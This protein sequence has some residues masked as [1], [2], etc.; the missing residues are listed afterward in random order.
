M[1]GL[2]A[3]FKLFDGYS[4]TI[5][6][7][8]PKTDAATNKILNASGATDKLN[9]KLAATGVSAGSAAK[10]LDKTVQKTDKMADDLSNASG[11]TDKL[12]KKLGATGAGASSAA[13]GL[14]KFIKAA[15]T[16]AM[17]KKGMDIVD[18]YANTSA[19]LALINDGLQTQ[20]ELQDKVFALAERSRGSYNDMASA[21]AKMG[22]LAKDA[23]TDNDELLAFTELVQKSFKIGGA[24][25]SEQQG[26][27][28]QLSQAMASG[29]LQG[30]ELVSI[31]ENAPMIY[32]AI[33]KYTGKSKG[34]LKKLSSDG[35]ITSQIIKDSMFMA[36]DDINS[37]F[38][39]M[40]KTFADGWTRMKDGAL[41]AFGPVMQN[42]IAILNRPETTAFI[43]GFTS[44]LNFIAFAINIIISTIGEV[45][46][47]ISYFWP[48]IEPIL[49]AIGAALLLW[50]VTQ[51]PMLITKLW[52][53]VAP[54]LA[55]AGAWALANMPILL[56]GAA[57][58]LLLYAILKFG[59]TVIE[60]VGVIGGIF[61]GLYAFML[62][63][64]AAMVNPFIS[65][66][67]FFAN[68]FNNPVYSIKKLFVDLAT[69]VLNLLQSIAEGIDNVLGS[70]M[71]DGLQ[72]LKDNMSEWLG[73][74]PEN[75]KEFTKMKMVDIAEYANNGYDVGKQAGSWA[76]NGVQDI[77]SKL[78][79]LFGMS[80]KGTDTPVK[81][82]GT[83][84][85]GSVQVNMAD[86]DLQYLRDIAERDYVANVANNTLAPQVTF[87]FGDIRETA[88]ADAIKKRLEEIMR[89]EIAV[90]SEGV[91]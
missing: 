16:L 45:I 33:A 86:E 67:E 12:N 66:A 8:I 25:T 7:I 37:K 41:K 17:L 51:I 84:S 52:L 40:P 64:I 28:R 34:E 1:V 13:A 91:Y 21:I 10:G 47:L 70:N 82:K 4:S 46:D 6:K 63:G 39:S 56:L 26:A 90:S 2:N 54:I 60:V 88:D 68:V 77:A 32:E 3:I 65:F 24:D 48:V 59:D 53:M 20:A 14:G 57:I 87:Q 61:G 62:N 15:I 49:V 69:N 19:R 74:K 31:M 73:D 55:Q 22:L 76:V 58:G 43:D 78:G 29:R 72:N 18:E 79:N 44:G 80:E 30:D 89:E 23:F 75:Y 81:V 83:G 5:N 85:G 35:F 42:I 9:E 36:A 38:A 50:G 27:M 71:A 11:A